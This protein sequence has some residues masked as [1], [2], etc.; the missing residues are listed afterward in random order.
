MYIVNRENVSTMMYVH[1][2]SFI[3]GHT[4]RECEKY[5]L[6]IDNT[7]ELKTRPEKLRYFRLKN[8]IFQS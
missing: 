3:K 8:A 5:N 7:D 1:S 2:F 4:Y 6:L